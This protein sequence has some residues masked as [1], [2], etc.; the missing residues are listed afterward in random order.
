MLR[1][2]VAG[3]LAHRL[4]LILTAVT[5]AIGV[6]L[7]AGTFILT[8]SAAGALGGAAAAAAPAQVVVQPAGADGGKSTAAPTSLAAGLVTQI[9]AVRGVASAQG[10]VAADKVTL[11]GKNGREITHRRA[12]NE[13][14]SYPDIP[15]LAAQYTIQ[16]GRPPRR[17]G[18]A[19]LDAATA[20]SLGYRVGDRIGVATTTTGPGPGSG[21]GTGTTTLT[22]VGIT[23]FGGADSPADAQLASFDA[24]TV[25]VVQAGTAQRLAGLPGRFTEIDALAAP[26]VS[27]A[28]LSRRLA[29]LLPPGAE[30]I[31]GGQ[32]AALQASDAASHLAS[33]RTDLLAFCLVALLVAAFVIANTFA[34]LVAQRTREY[35][36]LRVI[37]ASRGQVLRSALTEAAILGLAASGAGVG[38]GILAAAGLRGLLT[39][40]G[41][42]LPPD[43]LTFAPRTAV[44]ALAT[45]TVVTVASA[46][47]PARLAA[48]VEPIR[49]LREALPT[50][51]R[52]SRGRLVAGIIGI[53]AAV[54]LLVTGS[55]AQS[56]RSAV[57]VGAGA[58]LAIAALVTAAPLMAGPVAH[59]IAAP[60]AYLRGPSRGRS[61]GVAVAVALARDNSAANPRRTAATAAILTIG[62]AAAAAVSIVATSARAS[63]RDAIDGTSHAD[64][65]VLGNVG[66]G[67]ARAIAAQ[68]GVRTTMR[69][70]SPLVEVAGARTRVDG[71]DPGRAALL[72]NYG[73][74]TGARTALRGNAVFVSTLQADRHGW[75]IG[76]PVTINFGQG[77]P[78]TLLVAGTFADKRFTGDDYLMPITTLFRDM[79]DQLDSSD[80]LIRAAPG[81]RPRAIR[82]AI[83]TLIRGYP[84]NSL[85]TAAQYQS[86]QAAD[87][88]D[89]GHILGVLTALVALTV[90]IAALGIA[91]G[92]ALS[93]TERAREFGVMRALG[94]TRRQ[95]GAMIRAESVIM[96]LLGALPGA[97][98]GIGAGAAL[99]AALTRGQ[100]GVATIGVSPVQLAA[101]LAATCLAALL[102]GIVPARHAGRVPALRAIE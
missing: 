42:T 20:R 44:V 47:R 85:L 8:D 86:A 30:A 6:A 79:P 71:I 48:R 88:G 38:L 100:T 50:A 29:R 52:R 43:G 80:V 60:T 14:L 10:L 92:L 70:D 19:L 73:V 17:P 68:P 28:T 57:F 15:A 89:L 32:A 101:A 76:S 41:G 12:A 33:L 7:V 1:V 99:A 72:M 67:L 94:L 27:A 9:R 45:G 74:R 46:L 39:V 13:L 53:T 36:L 49:A 82:S 96:C 62:L 61:R 69:I 78:R 2:T 56:G 34:I 40:L 93:V 5:I 21:T 58:L 63:A 26:G 35:A 66:P 77:A 22:V 95:L 59:L 31:T 64:L 102:A 90:L 11:I 51:L 83:G 18:E 54:A 81:T 25:V 37:G 75:H 23:G 16:S 3:L 97:A 87:L 55:V 4:R 65:Y 84:G 98:I 91:N 24:P